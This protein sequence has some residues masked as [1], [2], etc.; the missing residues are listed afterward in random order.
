MGLVKTIWLVGF[1]RFSFF[2]SKRPLMV[3]VRAWIMPSLS[4]S[5]LSGA[6]VSSFSNAS[7]R[8][9][10]LHPC[11]SF[12]TLALPVSILASLVNPF[13]LYSSYV[14]KPKLLDAI[15]SHVA[16][17]LKEEREKQGISLNLLSQ[18]AGLSRQ[19][20]SYVEQE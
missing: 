10:L 6:V 2:I 8:T 11:D 7:A 19:T 15:S 17:I 4:P 3:S 9:D 20:V 16:R 18:K 14:P 13:F 12:E 5:I 1:I